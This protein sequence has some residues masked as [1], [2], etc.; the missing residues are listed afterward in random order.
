MVIGLVAG[1]IF[2]GLLDILKLEG[3]E[4][5]VVLQNIFKKGSVLTL[6]YLALNRSIKNYTAQKHLEVVNRHRQ[7]ALDTFPDLV[8]SSGNNPET[9][10]AVLSAATNAIFDANQSGYLSTKTK[11]TESVNPIQQVFG[12]M[13]SSSA[14]SED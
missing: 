12:A 4:W 13:R 6:F 10:H 3:T 11:G 7:R 9:R 14:R 1:I 8:E 2:W 5:T